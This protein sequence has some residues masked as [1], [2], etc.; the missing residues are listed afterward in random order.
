MKKR[1]VFIIL[2]ALLCVGCRK[3]ETPPLP[4]AWSVDCAY[5]YERA[6]EKGYD[7]TKEEWVALFSDKTDVYYS[8][9]Y[10][11]EHGNLIIKFHNGTS[12]DAGHYVHNYNYQ[13]DDNY[14]YRK[15]ECGLLDGARE[16]HKWEVVETTENEIDYV[17]SVCGVTKEVVVTVNDFCN[18]YSFPYLN[19]TLK[20][21]F[22]LDKETEYLGFK[23]DISWSIDSK[24]QSLLSLDDAGYKCLLT[25]PEKETEVSL[26]AK[27]TFNGEEATK[28]YSFR[29]VAPPKMYNLTIECDD[30]KV[31]TSL[32]IDWEIKKG[33]SFRVEQNI[34]VMIVYVLYNDYSVTYR[35]DVFLN[36]EEAPAEKVG[37]GYQLTFTM[38]E[39]T[40]LK[41]VLSELI[42][43]K[44]LGPE[45]G[46]VLENVSYKTMD[47]TAKEMG[48]SNGL[49]STGDVEVLVI[50]IMFNNSPNYDLSIIDKAFNG[51]KEDTGWNSLNSY[52]LTSSMGKLNITGNILDP[53]N[54]GIN[55]DHNKGKVFNDYVSELDFNE[56]YDYRF[57]T[58][59]LDYYDNLGFD[60]SK[61]D[62]NNDGVLDTVYLVYL[63]P[64]LD[65]S[66]LWW[67][68]NYNYLY[69]DDHVYDGLALD[70]YLWMSFEFFTSPINRNKVD[71][72]PIYIDINSE[73]LIHE[74]GHA[75]GL[76]DYYG[77]RF[78][79]A[80]MGGLGGTCMMDANQGDHDPFSKAILGWTN[81]TIVFNH[82][83]E[84]TLE[85]FSETGDSIFIAVLDNGT[86]FDEF[87]VISFY[88]PDGLNEYKKDLN[89]GIY[90][91][92]GVIVY[93]VNS[94]MKVDLK[95]AYTVH[96]IFRYKNTNKIER[97]IEIVSHGDN[98]IDLSYLSSPSD[99]YQEGDT[100]Y[101]EKLGLT[102]IVKSITTDGATVSITYNND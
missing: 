102:L 53:Y 31:Y 36:E 95:D 77:I 73:V 93:H 11:N 65:G 40:V 28:E 51:S 46:E 33:K 69:D 82:D 92:S 15:C 56:I 78:T 22:D 74:T 16:S 47:E 75:L 6:Q 71:D 30:E 79:G 61:Y 41:F 4:L 2:I 76:A 86:Y 38:T 70:S 59:A 50:P 45:D 83:Y 7:K 80:N 10:I 62:T 85:S 94:K 99:L 81:P 55:Y 32:Y 88:T 42:E 63:A 21:G 29:I 43:E 24:Y 12:M 48:L 49:S 96:E 18:K 54:T 9:M 91:I 52:Y 1:L 34:E 14:H 26:I 68:Y 97:L 20:E 72:E 84:V 58:E 90:G 66:D 37:S 39:D 101:I 25:L 17:C 44:P 98:D 64:F 3:R 67:A 13:H 27:F 35:L 8:D 89:I 87:Y 100:L 19:K 60:F 23:C 5:Y 57:L